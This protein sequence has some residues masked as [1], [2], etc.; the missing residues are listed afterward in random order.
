MTVVRQGFG[1]SKTPRLLLDEISVLTC[2]ILCPSFT[3]G[4]FQ[5]RD[6]PLEFPLEDVWHQEQG[7]CSV[8]TSL[9]TVSDIGQYHYTPDLPYSVRFPVPS[10]VSIQQRQNSIPVTP[11]AH[12]V[13]IALLVIHRSL[14]RSLLNPRFQVARLDLPETIAVL[15]P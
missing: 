2:A 10:L 7:Q 14:P 8:T 3:I 5:P 6:Q 9:K 11:V 1:L 15:Q 4:S 13:G 12:V